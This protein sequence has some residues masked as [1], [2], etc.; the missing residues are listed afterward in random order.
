MELQSSPWALYPN[1]VP[2]LIKE[3]PAFVHR[4]VFT[5]Y[6]DSE[7]RCRIVD[8]DGKDVFN[9]RGQLDFEI[10]QIEP[11]CI[12]FWDLQL[13]ELDSGQCYVYIK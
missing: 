7:H 11:G 13:L 12:P 1:D 10:V 4:F 3:G 9:V 6:I 2:G 5:N 8:R